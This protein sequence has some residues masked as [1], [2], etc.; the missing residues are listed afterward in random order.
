MQHDETYVA[1]NKNI[2]LT[3]KMS[4]QFCVVILQFTLFS[5]T[6]VTFII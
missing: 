4:L 5:F 2:C 6:L 3:W 1:F